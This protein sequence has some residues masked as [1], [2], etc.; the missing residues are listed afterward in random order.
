MSFRPFADEAVA[1]RIGDRAGLRRAREL[2][3]LLDAVVAALEGEGEALPERV[4]P[5]EPP[6]TVKNPFG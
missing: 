6:S 5:A 4:A 2:R 1:L 3:A